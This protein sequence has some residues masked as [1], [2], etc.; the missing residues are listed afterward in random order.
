MKSPPDGFTLGDR[1]EQSRHLSERLQVGAV[2]SDRRHHADRGH[3]LDADRA[4]SSIR[5]RC[6]RRTRRSWSRCSRPSRATTTTARRATAR[7]CTS[8]PQ[9]FLDEAGVK[10]TH[11]PYKGVGPMLTDLIGGQVDIGDAVAAVG[12]AAPEERRAARD[13]RRRD[14]SASPRRRTSRR[15]SSRACRA[16]WSRAGSPSSD[17]RRC[18]RPTSSASTTPFAA[19][20]ATPEV[21]RGDGEAGQHDQR[22]HAGIRAHS[23]S[24]ARST[25]YAKLVKKAGL[26]LQ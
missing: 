24:A 13:R 7:S 10:A 12:A 21:K 11:I 20:F 3:R 9:M 4:S 6:R 17:R 22:Q 14:A 16:T 18:R 23:S 26:E 15:W 2:R 25:K 8:P 19:A 5:T 1:V